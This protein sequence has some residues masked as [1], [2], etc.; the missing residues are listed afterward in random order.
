MLQGDVFTDS[1]SN[2]LEDQISKPNAYI[3]QSSCFCKHQLSTTGIWETGNWRTLGTG[4]LEILDKNTSKI[5]NW[6]GRWRLNNL[7]TERKL[8][9]KISAI[10]MASRIGNPITATW[11]ESANHLRNMRESE[12]ANN[13]VRDEHGQPT[14][15]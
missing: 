12:D 2:D 3:N 11:G 6:R 14:S 5:A 15:Q 13:A 1:L 8:Q 4:T 9:K 7:V 10:G